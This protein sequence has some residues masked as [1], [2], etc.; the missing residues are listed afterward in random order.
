MSQAAETAVLASLPEQQRQ[1]LQ[2]FREC[3]GVHDI[4][5]A[6][7]MLERH[8]WNAHVGS[9]RPLTSD[10]ATH[11]AC[12]WLRMPL[13]HLWM[14]NRGR[15]RQAPPPAAL[16]ALHRAPQRRHTG[17]RLGDLPRARGPRLQCWTAGLAGW[18]RSLVDGRLR[19]HCAWLGVYSGRRRTR[20]VSSLRRVPLPRYG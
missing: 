8:S 14:A 16:D 19:G 3:T 18:P 9:H 4:E 10:K 2:V 20:C 5:L 12:Y 6:M 13:A 17:A 15:A 11:L 7:Q 1:A